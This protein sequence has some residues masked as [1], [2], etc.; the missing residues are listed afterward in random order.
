MR[1]GLDYGKQEETAYPQLVRQQRE[2]HLWRRAKERGY[3]LLQQS[4]KPRNDEQ[5]AT[6]TEHA[7]VA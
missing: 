3:N 4:S 6:P 1:Y 5:A 7:N 2:K